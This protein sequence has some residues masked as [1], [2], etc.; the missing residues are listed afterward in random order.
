MLA[1][2][3]L[4]RPISL[5]LSFTL[6]VYVSLPLS[7]SPGCEV[8][9]KPPPVPHH[10]P[11]S[12]WWP[13]RGLGPEPRLFL[14]FYER[15]GRQTARGPPVLP[16]LTQEQQEVAGAQQEAYGGRKRLFWNEDGSYR[17]YQRAGLLVTLTEL[18]PWW[19]FP[20]HPMVTS[21]V[22]SPPWHHVHDGTSTMSHPQCHI[23]VGSLTVSELLTSTPG[24]TASSTLEVTS[25]T[26]HCDVTSHCDDTSM[27]SCPWSHTMKWD[28]WPNVT[29]MLDR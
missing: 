9:W 23:H 22:M 12:L 7:L 16:W 25:M 21:H 13:H 17:L 27:T 26:S 11:P 20:W 3:L 28:H 5:T 24:Q 18:P 14:L 8:I 10:G 1:L 19:H 4:K 15:I 29:S 2:S 6:S